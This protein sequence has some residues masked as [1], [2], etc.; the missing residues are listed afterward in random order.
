MPRDIK[1]ARPLPDETRRSRPPSR[2]CMQATESCTM[3]AAPYRRSGWRGSRS[4]WLAPGKRCPQP[5]PH[6]RHCPRTRLWEISHARSLRASGKE[7]KE[8]AN[9]RPV[10]H[11]STSNVAISILPDGTTKL[12]RSLSCGEHHFPLN[13]RFLAVEVK[14]L[15]NGLRVTPFAPS[16]HG[17]LLGLLRFGQR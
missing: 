2:S 6:Q 1:R 15:H 11:P 12:A 8:I 13:L 4:R 10:S 3:T 17:Q 14:Y 7:Y 16:K 9:P 5:R